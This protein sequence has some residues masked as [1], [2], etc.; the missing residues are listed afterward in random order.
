MWQSDIVIEGDDEAQRAVRFAL[1]NLYGSVREGSRR[2]VAP[3]GLT[4]AGY[5]GHIFWDAET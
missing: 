3:M 1:F 5:G 4:S 2:S